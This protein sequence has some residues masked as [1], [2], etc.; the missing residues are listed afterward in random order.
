MICYLNSRVLGYEKIII[1]TFSNGGGA[2][3]L[4]HPRP[5]T[6]SGREKSVQGEVGEGLV[7]RDGA[8]LPSLLVTILN[9]YN[10]LNNIKFTKEKRK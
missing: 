2:K 6:F 9:I 5:I 10:L 7:K 8:K 3:I 1:I 4:P